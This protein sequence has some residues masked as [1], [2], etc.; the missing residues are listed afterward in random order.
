MFIKGSPLQRGDSQGGAVY[1]SYTF[2]TFYI[3]LKCKQRQIVI[4]KIPK[5]NM[6]KYSS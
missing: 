2:Y 6:H 4:N 1:E 3:L 5:E